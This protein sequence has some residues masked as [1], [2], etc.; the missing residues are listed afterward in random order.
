MIYNWNELKKIA[1]SNPR[2]RILKNP[3]NSND[4]TL[5]GSWYA[6]NSFMDI[7]EDVRN[8][9]YKLNNI[10]SIMLMHPKTYINF[11]YNIGHSY[12]GYSEYVVHRHLEIIGAAFGKIMGD[13]SW[14]NISDQYEEGIVL[15]IAKSESPYVT[16]NIAD[17]VIVYIEVK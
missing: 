7:M 5:M 11:M 9:I 2:G 10:P 8:G 17:P 3:E 1:L 12:E 13:R 15:I 4:I 14:L 16:E 6:T